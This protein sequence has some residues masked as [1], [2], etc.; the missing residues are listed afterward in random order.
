MD[1][2]K[3]FSNSLFGLLFVVCA[4]TGYVTI[5]LRVHQEYQDYRDQLFLECDH[6]HSLKR[7]ISSSRNY[8]YLKWTSDDFCYVSPPPLWSRLFLSHLNLSIVCKADKNCKH[9]WRIK[10]IGDWP[11]HEIRPVYFMPFKLHQVQKMTTNLFY[12]LSGLTLICLVHWL[13]IKKGET[14]RKDLF[15]ITLWVLLS[16]LVV[17]FCAVFPVGVPVT[18]FLR[19]YR[20]LSKHLG[21]NSSVMWKRV[22]YLLSEEAVNEMA[23]TTIEIVPPNFN[24]GMYYSPSEI[25]DSAFPFKLLKRA[26]ARLSVAV[27]QYDAGMAG[28]FFYGSDYIFDD[29]LT[30]LTSRLAKQ[31]IKVDNVSLV[32]QKPYIKKILIREEGIVDVLWAGDRAP[33]NLFLTTYKS[34]NSNNTRFWIPIQNVSNEDN[35]VFALEVDKVAI[36]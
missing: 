16:I 22:E 36:W 9:L 15:F 14:E 13:L 32:I 17:V 12:V 1:P 30:N 19:E 5:E 28:R 11:V 34:Y 29:N 31:L 21:D 18:A 4:I 35:R 25:K 26:Q 27:A 10:L 6:C 20:V 3:T 8:K 7:T 24:G 23:N 2:V 33:R